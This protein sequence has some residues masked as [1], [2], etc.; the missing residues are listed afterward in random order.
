MTVNPARRSQGAPR[1]PYA[2][3][4]SILVNAL[5]RDDVACHPLVIQELALGS[6]KN[7]DEVLTLLGRLTQSPFVI[8]PVR[9]RADGLRRIAT[10]PATTVNR[11]PLTSPR[12]A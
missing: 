1:A 6:I 5:V 10:P 7:R 2:A 12:S 9:V 4:E 11:W 3:T 8:A